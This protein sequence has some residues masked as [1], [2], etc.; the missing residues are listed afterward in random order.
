MRL[1]RLGFEALFALEARGPASGVVSGTV[2]VSENG[3]SSTTVSIA[4]AV[5]VA[6]PHHRRS[7]V[8]AHQLLVCGCACA[9]LLVRVRVCATP[10][11]GARVRDSLCVAGAAV[12]LLRVLSRTLLESAVAHTA[13]RS[14]VC[15]SHLSY[16]EQSVMWLAECSVARTE[17]DTQ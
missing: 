3:L 1:K 14:A 17:R 6:T 9:R 4:N 15:A 12:H 7:A 8:L 13:R 11:A 5:G 10:C 2:K 16:C